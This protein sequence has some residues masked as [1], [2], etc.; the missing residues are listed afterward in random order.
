MKC[1]RDEKDLES[2]TS[3]VAEGAS[4]CPECRGLFL[5]ESALKKVW[6]SYSRE[7]LQGCPTRPAGACRGEENRCGALRTP[8]RKA[9]CRLGHLP[10]PATGVGPH[11]QRHHYPGPRVIQRRA[12]TLQLARPGRG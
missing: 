10:N 4:V 2:A 7:A 3:L 5:T 6:I 1:P 8:T 11:P 9:T 12:A